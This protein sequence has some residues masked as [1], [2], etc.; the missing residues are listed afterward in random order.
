MFSITNTLVIKS[1]EKEMILNS[2]KSY[3]SIRLNVTE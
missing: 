2:Q 1:A 3:Q